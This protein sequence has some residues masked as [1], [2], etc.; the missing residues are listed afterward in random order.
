M[1][2]FAS[3]SITSLIIAILLTSVFSV[4]LIAQT[5]SIRLE[6]IVWDPSGDPLPDVT[7]T[8]VEETTGRQ[9]ETVSDAE[10]YYRFLT[11]PPGAYTVTA[12]AKGFKD[13][14]LRNILLYSPDTISQNFSF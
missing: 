5:A 9:T 12:K 7:L 4:S 11:L 14:I 13:I 2:R 8:A 6:G 3:P 10:G 1:N